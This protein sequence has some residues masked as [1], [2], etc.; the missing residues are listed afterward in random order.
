MTGIALNAAHGFEHE[1]RHLRLGL[2]PR[3]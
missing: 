1:H 2:I 3:Q